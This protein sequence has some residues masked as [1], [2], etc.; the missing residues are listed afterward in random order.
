MIN[1]KAAALLSGLERG[2]ERR[3][4]KTAKKVIRWRNRRDEEDEE[5]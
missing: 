1:D 4:G 5:Q 3:R 2:E